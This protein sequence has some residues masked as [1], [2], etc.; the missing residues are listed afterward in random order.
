MVGGEE[1]EAQ[2]SGGP[3]QGKIFGRGFVGVTST[4]LCRPGTH[5]TSSPPV[6]G[7]DSCTDWVS[8]TTRGPEKGEGR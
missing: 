2:T 6:S 5:G 7:V 8:C 1:G 3:E 4:P